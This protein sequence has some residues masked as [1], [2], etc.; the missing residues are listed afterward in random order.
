[1]TK[2]CSSFFLCIFYSML[3]FCQQHGDA[4]ISVA[5]LPNSILDNNTKL[6]LKNKLISIVCAEGIASTEC[7]AIAMVP[8]VTVLEENLVE[9]GMRN[10]Y[11][12]QLSISVVVRDLITNTMFNSVTITCRGE[13]YSKVECMRNAIRKI[14]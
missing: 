8:E 11:T 3:A 5:M 4:Y 12:Q 13:G 14:K 2:L 9:G 7:C 10:I 1:M 6:I